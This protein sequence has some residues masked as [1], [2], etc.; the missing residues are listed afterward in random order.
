VLGIT[1]ACL[2]KPLLLTSVEFQF[3]NFDR[4]LRG[5]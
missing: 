2:L 5:K 4:A 3:G 1:M